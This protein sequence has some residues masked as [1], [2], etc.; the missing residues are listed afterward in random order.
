[1]KFSE[2]VYTR[3]DVAAVCEKAAALTEKLKNAKRAEEQIEIFEEFEKISS[4]FS[5][6]A[7]VASIRH[8]IDTRDKFYEE[9]NDFF[10]NNSPLIQEKAQEFMNTLLD[11]P[12]RKELEEKYGTLLFKNMEIAKKT[13]STEII[14]L[15]QKEN[16]LTS[17]Y[18]KLYATTTAEIDGNTLPITQSRPYKQN[19]D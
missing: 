11:S 5:T 14:P 4:A 17:E 7:T 13:F 2:I 12:F 16:A 19:R 15:L 3:P 18:Q 1:M 6:S 8:T 9:E 10:D